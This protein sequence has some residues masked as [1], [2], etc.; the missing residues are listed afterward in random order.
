MRPV[1]GLHKFS[2]RQ[3]NHESERLLCKIICGREKPSPGLLI[4]LWVCS[5]ISV[6]LTFDKVSRC[7]HILV[8][9][10][11]KEEPK[12]E[13]SLYQFFCISCVSSCTGTFS[14]FVLLTF[15]KEDVHFLFFPLSL[16]TLTCG[17]QNSWPFSTGICYL[18]RQDT[19]TTLSIRHEWCM[20]SFRR[21]NFNVHLPI[22]LVYSKWYV[23]FVFWCQCPL[24]LPQI[25]FKKKFNSPKIVQF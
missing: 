1:S 21:K 5:C 25:M 24:I 13:I 2:L 8:N 11:E 23:R 20:T 9:Q 4:N 22:K 12:L 16:D 6:A 7:G 3:T 10:T 14:Q 17:E 19:T 18:R 15:Q